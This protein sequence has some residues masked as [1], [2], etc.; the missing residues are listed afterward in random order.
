MAQLL[1]ANEIFFTQFQPK[2]ANRFVMYIE[3]IPSFLIRTA[4]RPS[5]TT[6]VVE[7]D[8]INVKRKVA[9]K[10]TWGDVTIQLYDPITPSGAQ[11]A[12]EWLR[13]QHESVTGRDGYA[14]FYKKD[15]TL[16]M[17]GPVGDFVEEWTLKGAFASSI[18]FSGGDWSSDAYATIDITLAYDYAVLQF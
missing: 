10:T 14:D 1:D 18:S 8:H 7:L 9:G 12:M 5:P 17:L 13:L 4:G 11:A 6:S 16:N 3:G 2:S 15:I